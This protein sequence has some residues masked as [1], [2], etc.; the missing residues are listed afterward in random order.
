M[1]NTYFNNKTFDNSTGIVSSNVTVSTI[2]NIPAGNLVA[3]SYDISNNSNITTYNLNAT[4]L[5]KSNLISN[6]IYKNNIPFCNATPPNIVYYD[7]ISGFVYTTVVPSGG[8]G[9]TSLTTNNT[10]TGLN[11]FNGGL[12]IAGP[13]STPSIVFNINNLSQIPTIASSYSG[14]YI[15]LYSSTATTFLSLGTIT[16]NLF[17]PNTYT[18]VD[19]P[20]LRIYNKILDSSSFI[21][22]KVALNSNF[23]NGSF[24]S[25]ITLL[26]NQIIDLNSDGTNWI[27]Y[28]ISSTNFNIASIPNLSYNNVFTGVNTITLDAASKNAIT[29]GLGS[30]LFDISGNYNYNSN[31]FP[32][33]SLKINPYTNSFSLGLSTGVASNSFSIGYKA[34]GTNQ[35]QYCG[36]IGFEAGMTSGNSS[37]AIGYQAGKSQGNQSVAIGYQS[38]LVQLDPSVAIGYQ[39]GLNQSSYAVAI[40]CNSGMSSSANCVAIGNNAGASRPKANSICI[41]VAAGQTTCGNNSVCIGSSA[42]QTNFPDN[43]ICLNATNVTINGVALQ[44]NSFYVAPIRLNAISPANLLMWDATTKEITYT[45]VSIPLFFY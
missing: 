18:G 25:S 39:C 6:L 27:V 20:S 13:L 41:G 1:S 35:G 36:A 32:S 28:G 22:I 29:A 26:P 5:N 43:C 34:G 24:V 23:Y 19:K 4:T 16:I 44:T 31:F 14:F 30:S 7:S 17:N 10:W 12:S 37:T 21:T 40:G 45:N 38:G 15:A 42:G 2:N 8:G 9:G 33:N 3:Y 11:I